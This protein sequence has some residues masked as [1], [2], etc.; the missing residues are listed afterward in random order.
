MGRINIIGTL[1]IRED[2]LYRLYDFNHRTIGGSTFFLL[3]S[4]NDLYSITVPISHMDNYK[5]YNGQ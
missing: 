1:F 3:I 5:I 2:V 4:Q